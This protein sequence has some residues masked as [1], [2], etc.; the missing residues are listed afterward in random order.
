MKYSVFSCSLREDSHSALMAQFAFERLQ[1]S[2]YDT[3]YHNLSDYN[4]PIC[5][6][7]DCYS[8]PQVLELSGEIKSTDGIILA[9]PVYN[10]NIC[11]SAKNLLELTGESWTDKV[12]G[13]I[14]AAGGQGSYMSIMSFANSLM[15][16]FRCVIIPR[17][18]FATR[19]AFDGDKIIDP[20]IEERLEELTQN[21]ARFT[22]ALR[23]T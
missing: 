11:A 18:V 8:H 3:S 7:G 23:Q 5:D 2:K 14:C 6:A 19:Q 17:F 9:S 20:D 1:Q 4:L 16:D 15:L 13:F 21:L 12:V 22:E 10:Y